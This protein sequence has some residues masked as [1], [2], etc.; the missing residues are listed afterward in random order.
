MFYETVFRAL[1]KKRVRYLV[2]G[3]VAVNLYGILRATAD[4]DLF[5]WLGSPE[6]VAKFVQTMKKLGYRPRVPV[7]PEDLQD[8]QKRREW[9]RK[10]GALV[11]TFVHPNSFE[12]VDIFL[13]DPIPFEAA[14]RRRRT[15]SIAD[16]KISV[17]SLNDLKTMK[18]KAGREKDKSDLFNLRKIEAIKGSQ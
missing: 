15:V 1:Q 18:K 16:F 2:A 3:G 17:V 7:P 13:K 14:Y 8:P 10:K 9:Q 12:Q 4:L 11:F 6:N 5:L